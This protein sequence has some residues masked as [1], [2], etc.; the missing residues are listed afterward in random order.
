MELGELIG[1]RFC[2]TGAGRNGG[3]AETWTAEDTDTGR[4]VLVKMIRDRLRMSGSRLGATELDEA[5][6]F[7]HRFR[8][9]GDLLKQLGGNGV[10]DLVDRGLH[11]GCAFIAMEFI[12]G[13]ALDEWRRGVAVEV[14][15][16]AC[17]PLAETLERVHMFG[18]VHRDVKPHNILLRARDGGVF[19]IDFGIAY[20]THPDA[21]RYTEAGVTPGST[22]Y[23]APELLQGSDPTFDA[24]KYGF[25]VVL[26]ELFTAHMP[27]EGGDVQYRQRHER[28]PRMRT[29]VPTLPEDLDDLVDR[30]LERDPKLRPAWKEVQDVLRRHVPR[31]GT[32]APPGLV[33]DPTVVFRAGEKA[34]AVRSRRGRGRGRGRGSDDAAS[35]DR[36]EFLRLVPEVDRMVRTGDADKVD[37]RFEVV[38]DAA[39]AHWGLVRNPEVTVGMLRWADVLREAK[40]DCYLAGRRYR[41]VERTLRRHEGPEVRVLMVEAKIGIAECLIAE[42]GPRKLDEAVALWRA[43]AHAV[44]EWDIR[45]PWLRE[46]LRQVAVNLEECGKGEE[47]LPVMRALDS[48]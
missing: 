27:F 38:L 43:A 23:R 30:L 17:L 29:H 37:E 34:P 47:T 12:E 31:A 40:G 8:R 26:Y 28:S 32:L 19:L 41:E 20:D 13:V 11:M 1:G 3:M 5:D 46:R 2:V 15:V 10:P 21:T 4:P 22:G 44:V 16:A 25:G 42:H 7:A 36:A 33:P 45:S 39:R 14:A 9:E 18:F 6:V 24:D 35:R 48:F